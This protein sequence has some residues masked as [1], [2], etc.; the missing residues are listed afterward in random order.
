VVTRR[1]QVWQD[2][3]AW[4][5]S[6]GVHKVAR[7]ARLRLAAAHQDAKILAARLVTH[8]GRDGQ[9]ENWALPVGAD[10]SDGCPDA[11]RKTARAAVGSDA[12]L[13]RADG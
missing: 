4:D 8:S 6:D 7:R 2:A 9:T 10:K 11:D 3:P 5:A 12:E 1:F 13:G